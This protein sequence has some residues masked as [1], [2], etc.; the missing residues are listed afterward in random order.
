[1]EC[2][3]VLYY[4]SKKKKTNEQ[5]QKNNKKLSIPKQ[6]WL[7]GFHKKFWTTIRCI[8]LLGI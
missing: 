8:L 7:P 5:Q 2:L 4:L 1:M 6:S 3:Y